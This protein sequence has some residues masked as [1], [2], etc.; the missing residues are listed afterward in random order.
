MET[1]RE[2]FL[3]ILVRYEVIVTK[4]IVSWVVI[5]PSLEVFSTV[6]SLSLFMIHTVKGFSVANE[7][8]DVFWNSFAFYMTQQ[9]WKS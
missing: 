7:A 4:V 6:L 9:I 3:K 5:F 1:Q 8:E 2:Y